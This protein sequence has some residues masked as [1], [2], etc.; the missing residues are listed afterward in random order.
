MTPEISVRKFW[1][2]DLTQR[3]FFWRWQRRRRSSLE[4][5]GP[6]LRLFCWFYVTQ[7]GPCKD[8]LREKRG[9]TTVTQCQMWLWCAIHFG[10]ISHCFGERRHDRSWEA[11]GIHSIPGNVNE[12]CHQMTAQL[13]L[14]GLRLR[15]AGTELV[16]PRPNLAC[17]L[18]LGVFSRRLLNG[19]ASGTLWKH[20]Q[21]GTEGA[22]ERGGPLTSLP[23]AHAHAHSHTHADYCSTPL[24]HSSPRV[25][26]ITEWSFLNVLLYADDL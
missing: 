4:A 21:L 11:S 2:R 14:A 1:H 5:F 19:S 23:P 8:M 6:I 17:I 20:L 25:F 26:F 18:S 12:E 13:D 7:S 9:T 15:N 22:R 10:G 3:F 24:I 16:P